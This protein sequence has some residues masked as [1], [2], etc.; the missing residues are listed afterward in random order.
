MTPTSGDE[1]G[2]DRRIGHIG[3]EIVT[4]TG[5]AIEVEETVKSMGSGIE[6]EVVIGFGMLRV[7]EPRYLV[8]IFAH[9]T[10]IIAMNAHTD[11]HDHGLL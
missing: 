11:D 4:E 7:W 5:T 10:Q 9:A 3:I 2:A 6:V 1:N 8:G